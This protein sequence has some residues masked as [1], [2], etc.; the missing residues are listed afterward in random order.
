M[1]FPLAFGSPS[2][3]HV[4]VDQIPIKTIPVV[5]PSAVKGSE[6]NYVVLLVT[7]GNGTSN[8]LAASVVSGCVWQACSLTKGND[9]MA[10]GVRQAQKLDILFPVLCFFTNSGERY[11]SF[12]REE[13]TF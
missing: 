6:G 12:P 4:R 11:V 10:D 13:I 2:D 7:A 5:L 9:G 3:P 1:R 8:R